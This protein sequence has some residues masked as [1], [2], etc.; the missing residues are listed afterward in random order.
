MNNNFHISDP[1]FTLV[2]PERHLCLGPSTLQG[3]PLLSYNPTPWDCH[4]KIY[5]IPV[6]ILIAIL[7]V[8]SS[9]FCIC[10]KQSQF[11]PVPKLDKQDKVADQSSEANHLTQTN[12]SVVATSNDSHDSSSSLVSPQSSIS[13]FCIPIK[14]SKGKKVNNIKKTSNGNV[15]VLL[16]EEYDSDVDGQQEPQVIEADAVV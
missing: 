8:I 9:V 14:T 3:T 1:H 2:A 5:L 7:I 10:R 12:G 16:K 6:I 13:A 4:I 15:H 11:N